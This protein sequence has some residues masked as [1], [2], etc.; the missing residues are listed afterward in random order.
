[1]KKIIYSFLLLAA[2]LFP[3]NSLAKEGISNYYVDATVQSNGDIRV[4]ELFILEGK[5]NGYER[6]IRYY[7]NQNILDGNSLYNGDGIELIKIGSMSISKNSEFNDLYKGST[8]FKKTNYADTGDYG[9]YTIKNVSGGFSYK[10][11]NPSNKQQN[12]FYIEYV[13]KNMAISHDDVAE[14]YW[15]LFSNEQSEYINNL[16]IVINIPNNK[17]ELRTWAHGPLNGEVNIINKEKVQISI[18]KLSSYNELDVRLV[19]DNDV[20]STTNKRS[21]ISSLQNII[22]YEEIKI[23]EANKAREE[24]RDELKHQEIIGNIFNFISICYVILLGYTVKKIYIKYDKE[25]TSTFKTQYYRDIPASYGPEVV[26]YLLD[27]NIGPNQ[28]SSSLLNLIADKFIEFEEVGKKDYLLKKSD[29]TKRILTDGEQKLINWFFN[30]IGDGKEVKLKDIKNASN[31]KY[32][33]FLKNYNEWKDTVTAEAIKENFFEDNATGKTK[34]ILISILGLMIALFGMSYYMNG[35]IFLIIISSSIIS[36]VYFISFTKRTIKGNED[37][38]RWMGLKNFIKD[39]GKF[40]ERDLPQIVLWEKYLVYASVF[41]LA[42]R[43][44]KTMKIKFEE[45]NPNYNG[46]DLIFNMYYF[47]TFNTFNHAITNS[48]GGAVN[49]ALSAKS[50]AAS[51]NSSSGGFGGGFSGGGGFGGG[52][53]GG[54]RF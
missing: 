23:E 36:L 50:I 25:H 53:G 42:E 30:E 3:L 47:N 6:I 18:K 28:L 2:L 22:K 20:L 46:N 45:I 34:G 9:I 29:S 4:K 44:S 14:L 35:L 41:G 19:F 10:I 54:G 31:K 49:T 33:K 12:G 32:E 40:K 38:L 21:G 7:N 16:E 13:I 26:K 17:T 51:K 1:M 15:N 24:A 48:V 52:G 37:Y 11:Y 8:D 43:L 27:R 5:F 39:F